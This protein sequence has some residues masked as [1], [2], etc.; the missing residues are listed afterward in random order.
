M[1]K[2]KE[3][4]SDTLIYGISSVFARFIGYLLVPLH[5]GV[6]PE[7]QY[8]IISLVFAAIALFNVV[9]TM[10][11][12]STYIRYGKDR[13]KAKDIFKT[14]Q[15][16]LLGTSSI[17]V[18][19]IWLLQPLISP[20][21]GLESGDPVLWMML[22][23]LFFD[24]LAVV[25]FAELRVNRRPK[26]FAALKTGNV[27]VNLFLNFYLI[28]VL[29]YGIE[30]V[31]ISNLAASFLT[32]IATAVFTLPLYKGSWDQQVLKRAL[33]FGLPFI[34]AG[35]GHAINE[36]IDRF[37]LKG[38]E[39]ETVQSLYGADYTP[40]DVVG[41]YSACY[42]LAVFMLLIVQMFR[43]A[44]QPFFMR[45]SD[46][47]SAPETFS[48]AFSAFNVAAAAVF[49]G[50][51]L[52]AEQIVS[53]QVPYFDFYLV[54]KEYWSGL[55]IVPLLLGAYWFQGWYINF[56]AG[57]F[58]SENTRSLA[59][60]TL[61]GALITIICNIILVPLYGMMGA[62]A[63]TLISYASMAMLIYYYSTRAYT[64]P[65][66]LGQGLAVMAISAAALWMEPYLTAYLDSFIISSALLLLISLSIIVSLSYSSVKG[67]S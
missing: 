13:D 55:Q 16:F 42:K 38:M 12:E 43:M 3:L 8:G 57:I 53:I 41:I 58:I 62:A 5:T 44:W 11:M 60:I 31:F 7:G 63:A 30:A 10:G 37:F 2:L 51:A 46:E 67:N 25:P 29:E 17:F 61:F 56:S 24:T 59:R 52:F 65:Y 22:G 36:L 48:Q 26:L 15:L 35:F 32:V 34:P 40:D 27:L 50:V 6:F 18:V 19:L 64:V 49:L 28:L 66:R 20:Q 23:I 47:K 54:D 4:F 45:E 33:S 39:P 9:F 14:L 1:K 21:L